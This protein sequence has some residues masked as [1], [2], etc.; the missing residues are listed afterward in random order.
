MVVPVYLESG[1]RRVFAGAFDWPGWCRGGRNEGEALAA[2]V[3]YGPR[4][5]AVVGPEFTP[6]ADASA[7][8]VVERLEGNA[9]TDFGAPAVEPRFD[10]RPV[11][12]AE[13]DR[14][15]RLLSA[16]WTAFDAAVAGAHGVTLRKGPRGGGRDLDKIVSHVFEADRAYLSSLGGRFPKAGGND[17][18]GLREACLQA[19]RSRAHGEP[20]A[21]SR[22]TAAPWTARY[23]VRRSAWHVLDHVWEIEDR[24]TR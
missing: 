5:A 15:S 7:L 14:L 23:F 24:A 9:T 19:L 11:D 17:M 22:R 4:Y 6:P 1:P 21:P 8:D 18:V 10:R 2:L 13:L 3:A 16:A 20:P 12:D